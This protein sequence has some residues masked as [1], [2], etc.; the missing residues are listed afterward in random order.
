[1]TFRCI[2]AF[3]FDD[4]VY[5]NGFQAEDNDPIL[6]THGTH[7]AQVEQGMPNRAVEQAEATPGGLR[8]K[9]PAKKAPAKKAA[10]KLADDPTPDVEPASKEN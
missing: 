6:K 10:P 5:P 8:A 2:N 4:V 1:M 7:F 9:T 3:V